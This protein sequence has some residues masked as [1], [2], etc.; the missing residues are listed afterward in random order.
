M[1]TGLVNR[2]NSAGA[3]VNDNAINNVPVLIFHRCFKTPRFFC[4][5]RDCNV[6]ARKIVGKLGSG[7]FER[8]DLSTGPVPITLAFAAFPV[9]VGTAFLTVFA[10]PP[11]AGCAVMIRIS[12]MQADIAAETE[13]QAEQ[14]D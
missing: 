10:A 6:L 5:I 4:Y 8:G 12:G 7:L 1:E 9:A 11:S 14:Y 2:A 3:F 13:N